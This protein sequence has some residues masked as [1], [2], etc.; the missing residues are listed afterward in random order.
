MG[1]AFLQTLTPGQSSA[2]TGLVDS[3]KPA[4]YEIVDRREDVV[5][6][7]RRFMAGETPDQA[8]VLSLMERYGELDG[9]IVYSYAAAFAQVSQTLTAEQ[10]AELL[11]LRTDLLGDLSFPDGAYLY[12]DPIAMPDILNTDFLFAVP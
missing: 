7:L 4:L 6:L 9:E 1:D 8:A 2:I 5:T 10:Q 11:T 12:S 3:Q